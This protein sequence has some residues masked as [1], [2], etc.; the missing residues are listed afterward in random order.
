MV[1]GGI[2]AMALIF[3]IAIFY[4]I[5]GNLSAITTYLAFQKQEQNESF[6]P[7]E[8]LLEAKRYLPHALGFD[9]YFYSVL[10]LLV[11]LLFLVLF[12]FI[13][14]NFATLFQ[15][16]SGPTDWDTLGSMFLQ[17]L[18]VGLIV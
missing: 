4:W 6:K 5:M 9:G 7:K 11:F 2:L 17:M 10:A 14:G 3:G 1:I 15:M 18:G 13:Q 12:P 16:V 8:I